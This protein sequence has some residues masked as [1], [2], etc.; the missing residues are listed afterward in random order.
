M[1]RE[2]KKKKGTHDG[3]YYSLWTMAVQVNGRICKPNL[4]IIEV[5]EWLK[6]ATC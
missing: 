2:K 1:A 5:E 6:A 4:V 3:K